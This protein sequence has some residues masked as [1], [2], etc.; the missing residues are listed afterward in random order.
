MRSPIN[1]VISP[2]FVIALFVYLVQAF[3]FALI[4]TSMTSKILNNKC[5]FIT[6][7]NNPSKRM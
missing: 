3:V 4:R 6:C 5:P 2:T 7:N 1:N